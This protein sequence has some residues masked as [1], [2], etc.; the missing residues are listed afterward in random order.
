MA[1]SRTNLTAAFVAGL[2]A[3]S[4]VI[5]LVS[6]TVRNATIYRD[7]ARYAG[8]EADLATSLILDAGEGVQAVVIG[9]DTAAEALSIT[10]RLGAMLNS[11]SNYLVVTDRNGSPL[12][13]S[14]AVKRL[15]SSDAALLADQLVNLP[16]NGPAGLLALDSA[17]ERVLLVARSV[18]K[19]PTAFGKVIVGVPT[20]EATA[21][22]REYTYAFFFLF[23]LIGFAGWG[24]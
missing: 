2:I 1:S 13:Q 11:F 8:T 7:V 9:P 15:N 6:W 23:P 5:G 18:A 16:V 14:A 21:L 19:S 12:F 17:G 10:P 20:N 22:P 3:V 24:A 4:G